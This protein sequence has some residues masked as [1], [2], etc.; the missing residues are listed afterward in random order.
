VTPIEQQGQKLALQ[1][2]VVG[3]LYQGV[4]NNEGTE[5]SGT[6]TQSGSSLPLKLKKA[7]EAK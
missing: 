2:K 5:L 3:G 1:V 6:W 7:A 4:L